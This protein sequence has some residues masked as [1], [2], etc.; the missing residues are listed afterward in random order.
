MPDP[1]RFLKGSALP[2]LSFSVRFSGI[3]RTFIPLHPWE[4]VPPHHSYR[5]N[6]CSTA[7]PADVAPVSALLDSRAC[8]PVSLSSFT[9][10]TIEIINPALPESPQFAAG[11]TKLTGELA[12]CGFFLTSSAS[13]Y[14][15]LA[16]GVAKCLLTFPRSPTSS[17]SQTSKSGCS[18]RAGLRISRCPDRSQ[19]LHWSD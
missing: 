1:F 7:S 8:I 11:S 10:P 16:A 6:N 3:E 13:R 9:A 5:T 12:K 2:P 4:S 19:R 18:I 17:A 14:R 15:G